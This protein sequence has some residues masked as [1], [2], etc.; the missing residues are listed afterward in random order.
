MVEVCGE[1]RHQANLP[2]LPEEA[3]RRIEQL[4]HEGD[5]DREDLLWIL[6]RVRQLLLY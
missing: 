4:M 5:G 6:R 3:V 1:D 2:S